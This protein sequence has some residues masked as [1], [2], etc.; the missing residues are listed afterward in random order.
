[1]ASES[2]K[3]IIAALIGNTMVATTKFIASA[4]TGSSAMFSEA[5]HSVVDTGNQV[6]M[7]YGM[8]RGSLPADSRFPFGHGKE[9]YF[10]SFIVAIMIFGVGAG[11]SA[12][13]GIH[14]LYNPR[15]FENPMV[16][17][18]VLSLAI[19]FEGAAWLFA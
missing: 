9:V 2:K 6:L 5:I 11:L 16:N 1:M 19:V 4:I 13:E 12:Y 17:Y 3:V 18:I 15:P 8:K 7:L 14:S 10:W